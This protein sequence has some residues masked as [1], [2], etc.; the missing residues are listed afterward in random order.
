MNF[1]Q[2]LPLMGMAGGA[3]LAPFT[4][5]MSMLPA[6]MGAGGAL[7]GASSV[8]MGGGPQGQSMTPP[9]P[10][11]SPP[12]FQPKGAATADNSL[13][14]LTQMMQSRPKNPFGGGGFNGV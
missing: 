5:G 6:M 8:A 10:P 2:M 3:A 9:P 12:P 13:Q 14:S 11:T 4:G 7:G 1:T